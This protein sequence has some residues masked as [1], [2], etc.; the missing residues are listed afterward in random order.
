M[1]QGTLGSSQFT[2]KWIET[3]L[4][5]LMPTPDGSLGTLELSQFTNSMFTNSMCLN[6]HTRWVFDTL[7]QYLLNLS[8]VTSSWAKRNSFPCFFHSPWN[9][10]YMYTWI[11]MY[12]Y[13]RAYLMAALLLLP[14]RALSFQISFSSSWNLLIF[15]FERANTRWLHYSKLKKLTSHSFAPLL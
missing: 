6:A 4:C 2:N 10:S 9:L 11:Y 5:V 1:S 14:T 15:L 12:T 13:L 7:P 3:H 8:A